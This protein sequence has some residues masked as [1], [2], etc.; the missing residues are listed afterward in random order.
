MLVTNYHGVRIRAICAAVPESVVSVD[1]FRAD[2]GD[3]NVD[4]FSQMTGVKRFRK[5]RAN[6]TAGDLTYAAAN[7]LLDKTKIGRKNIG[8]LVFVT[9]KPDFR[10][11]STA[12]ALHSRLGL[13]DNCLCF[14]INLACSGFVYGL[15]VLASLLKHSDCE[16]GLLLVGDT[17]SRT[18]SP[19]DNTMIMLFGDCGSACLLEKN[20]GSSER[21]SFAFRSDGVR[22]NAIFTPA[23]GYE[24]MLGKGQRYLSTDSVPRSDYEVRMNGMDVFGFS[25]TDVPDLIADYLKSTDKSVD[26]YDYLLL[27]QANLYIMQQIKRRVKA[28][29]VNV[30]SI[31]SD[32]GNTSSCSIPLTIVTSVP[33]GEDY[34][35]IMCG[36]GAGLSWA[37]ADVSL[38]E[39]MN[40]NLIEVP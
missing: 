32:Y 33:H 6:Q 9:Q 3:E 25:I 23:G 15:S 20:G 4:K 5:A 18:I 7:D 28:W 37:I 21:M 14:D 26:E 12:Y 24:Q 29:T 2:F 19:H 10:V 40:Q 36:F 30:P 38:S 8:V 35:V 34:K 17:S 31:I 13:S 39:D 27:H 22:S 16:Y 1:S 11:P